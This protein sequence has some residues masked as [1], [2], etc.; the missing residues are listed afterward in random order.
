M[1]IISDIKKAQQMIH[2]GA[3][4]AYP[5]E[6]IYGFGCSPYDEIAVKRL[7]AI[8][9]RDINKGLILLISD[10]M[11]LIDLVAEDIEMYKPKI[12]D[13]WPGH[14]TWIFPKSDKV[15]YFVSGAH[16]SIAIR[17][18]AHETSKKLCES[19]PIISTSANISEEAPAKTMDCILK[20][21]TDCIDGVVVGD[22]G[23]FSQPS[24]IYD[25]ITG[26]RL[27]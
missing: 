27:R 8:K 13:T 18:T 5:T 17:M 25:V 23:G 1:E 6:A 15:P 19:T 21:F 12:A 24:S 2:D 7:L 20:N 16:K 3:V 9:Q 10:W 26:E 11:Q 22:L 14:V 4:I